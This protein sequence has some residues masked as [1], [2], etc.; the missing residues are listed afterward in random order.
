MLAARF[1]QLRDRTLAEVDRFRAEPVKLSFFKDGALDPDRPAREIEAIL[2]ADAGRDASVSGGTD[3]DWRSRVSS[4]RSE[5]HVDRAK[6]PDI[7]FKRGDKVKA[8]ARPG[9]PWFEVLSVD[10]RSEPRLIL[11]MGEA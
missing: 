8:L 11:T 5:L 10:D 6:Y 4:Q 2:R 9:E 1:H 7:A 3:R